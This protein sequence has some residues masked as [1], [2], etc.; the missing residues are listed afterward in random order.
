[1]KK[2]TPLRGFRGCRVVVGGGAGDSKQPIPL[3]AVW[4]YTQAHYVR[5]RNG[6]DVENPGEFRRALEDVWRQRTKIALQAYRDAK[7][8]TAVANMERAHGFTPIPDSG[9]AC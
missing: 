3:P 6:A 8:A 9:L 4:Y 2:V 5:H 7:S 1:M